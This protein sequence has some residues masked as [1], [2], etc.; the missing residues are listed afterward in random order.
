MCRC[1]FYWPAQPYWWKLNK[2]LNMLIWQY[3]LHVGGQ[4][5]FSNLSS[6]I[7]SGSS[8]THMVQLQWNQI[9]YQGTRLGPF[10]GS[11]MVG[12]ALKL[13]KDNIYV[14]Q[15]WLATT[16]EK[17]VIWRKA[18]IPSCQIYS[19][20]IRLHLVFQPVKSLIMVVVKKQKLF[21]YLPNLQKS[22]WV[23]KGSKSQ[24]TK[25]SILTISPGWHT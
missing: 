16:V 17:K 12:H 2:F 20:G 15:M 1:K 4:V 6:N 21:H 24:K 11:G 8:V 14:S 19:I 3:S 23:I 7:S 9:I 25:Y 5:H 18:A 22:I 13:S 10:R